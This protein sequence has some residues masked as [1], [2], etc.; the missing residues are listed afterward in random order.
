MTTEHN[1]VLLMGG[2]TGQ[3]VAGGGGGGA[4]GAPAPTRKIQ[5]FF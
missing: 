4:E 3:Y 1:S 2:R 5:F